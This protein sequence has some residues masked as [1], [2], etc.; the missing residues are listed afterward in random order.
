M[1]LGTAETFSNSPGVLNNLA[2][3]V[4]ELQAGASIVDLVTFYT[5]F[6]VINNAGEVDVTAGTGAAA[7]GTSYVNN[8]GNVEVDSGTLNVCFDLGSTL[9]NDGG[10]FTAQSGATLNLFAPAG[11]IR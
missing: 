10:S 6:S 4:I 3:G 2:A 8:T 7:I 11:R 5:A 9:T 1:V